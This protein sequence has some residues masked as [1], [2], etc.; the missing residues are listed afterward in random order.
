MTSILKE[1][2]YGNVC[3]HAQCFT[4]DSEYGSAMKLVT[5]NEEKLL[6]SLGTDR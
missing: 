1:F 4:K 2:S 3:P 5:H 6:A